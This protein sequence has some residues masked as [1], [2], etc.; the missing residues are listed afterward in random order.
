MKGRRADRK[1]SDQTIIDGLYP[2][3]DLAS[4]RLIPYETAE[5]EL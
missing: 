4:M 5:R 3:F 1:V 2:G